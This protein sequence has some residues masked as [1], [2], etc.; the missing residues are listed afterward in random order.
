MDF[1]TESGKPDW[2]SLGIRWFQATII[3]Y[4]LD[5]VVDVET[6]GKLEQSRQKLAYC[7]HCHAV[8][9]EEA[10]FLRIIQNWW[11][12]ILTFETLDLMHGGDKWESTKAK[13]DKSFRV[14]NLYTSVE[15]GRPSDSRKPALTLTSRVPAENPPLL[16]TVRNWSMQQ[17]P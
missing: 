10:S 4:F 6:E 3:W 17:R 12:Q 14:Q 16:Q 5:N 13:C 15:T 8:Q 9:K 11:S 7:I 2:T 1:E